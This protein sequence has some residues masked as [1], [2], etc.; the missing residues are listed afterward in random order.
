MVKPW[1]GVRVPSDELLISQNMRLSPP[2][3]VLLAVHQLPL[4]VVGDDAFGL[5][6]VQLDCADAGAQ[7]VQAQVA[8][9]ESGSNES[10]YNSVGW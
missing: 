10:P 3:H 8:V 4:I 6:A 7:A 2:P 9:S 1:S 5:F